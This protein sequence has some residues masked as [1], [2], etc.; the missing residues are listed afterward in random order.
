MIFFFRFFNLEEEVK[1][2][3]VVDRFYF[4]IFVHFLIYLFSFLSHSM[5]FSF[6]IS[7]CES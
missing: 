1:E 6:V 2:K 7:F 5:L 3:S 4:R